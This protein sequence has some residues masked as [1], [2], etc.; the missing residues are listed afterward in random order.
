MVAGDSR[1]SDLGTLWNFPCAPR[2]ITSSEDP[3][4]LPGSQEMGQRVNAE[5][6]AG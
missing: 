1:V 5:A 2:P 4:W 6:L 3:Q